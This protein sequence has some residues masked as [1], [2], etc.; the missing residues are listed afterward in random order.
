MMV[1]TDTNKANQKEVFLNGSK[2]VK[3][4]KKIDK[5]MIMMDHNKS[6]QKKV[7]LTF[8]KKVKKVKTNKILKMTHINWVQNFMIIMMNQKVDLQ[9]IL[10]IKN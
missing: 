8:S 3:K 4:V 1:M 10:K 5:I 2:K 9:Q 6:N 7:A